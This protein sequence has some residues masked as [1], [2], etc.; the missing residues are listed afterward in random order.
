MDINDLTKGVNQNNLNNTLKQFGN[1]M[2]KDQMN[3]VVNTIKNTN[4]EQLKQ[5]LSKIDPKEINKVLSS[6]P[7]LQREVVLSIFKTYS[8]RWRLYE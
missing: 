4:Q 6:N 1:V 2:S 7:G 8:E 5:Q 3:Q